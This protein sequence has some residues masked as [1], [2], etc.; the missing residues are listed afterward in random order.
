MHKILV[1]DLDGTLAA[2]GKGMTEKSI[3]RLKELEQMG[4][5]ITVC[6]GKPTYYLCGFMRQIGLASPILIGENGATFQFGV[7]LPPKVF[8][9]YPHSTLAREQLASLRA[10]FDEALPER[11]WY[12]PNE[13]ALT[14]FPPDEECFSVIQD[15]I[16]SAPN[17]LSEL[18]AYRHAD[19][20]D[21]IPKTISKA[22]GLAYLA[23]RL[24]L[25]SADFIAIGDGPNDL[26]MFAFADIA[27][28]IG[29][30]VQAYV[31]R[32]FGEIEEALDFIALVNP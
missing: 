4:Y 31:D 20:F 32:A 13:V 10:R 23:E 18:S 15:L 16:D 22:N 21:I 9:T 28:G 7:D 8:F 5:R 17:A 25:T 3:K 30:K 26:S 19:S 11:L 2:L 24:E 29:Q 27:L 14:P 6:S 1:F 12:Q